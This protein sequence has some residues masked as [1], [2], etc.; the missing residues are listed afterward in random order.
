MGI[1]FAG[2]AVSRFTMTLGIL[3]IG[4]LAK[5]GLTFLL[6]IL[7]CFAHVYVLDK[8]LIIET[9]QVMFAKRLLII[10]FPLRNK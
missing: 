8:Y 1:L 10:L 3:G 7:M 4:R 2:H 6:P 9:S 5:Q